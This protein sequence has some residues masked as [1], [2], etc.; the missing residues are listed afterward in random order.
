MMRTFATWED[1]GLFASYMRSEGYF[2]EV[3]DQG[4][5]SLYGPAAI[6][7]IRV[8]L[9]DEPVTAI[10]NPDGG[11][12]DPAEEDG[13]PPM[14]VADEGEAARLFRMLIVGW[15]V[16]SMIVVLRGFL[17]VAQESP[18]GVLPFVW[19]AI[20]SAVL[21]AGSWLALVPAIP[22]ICSS[23]RKSQ[24]SGGYGLLFWWVIL[25]LLPGLSLL[26]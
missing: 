11:A 19:P 23:I 15:V 24:E 21:C 2:A 16:I 8:L 13:I 3:L 17:V 6:G 18:V 9:S 22:H 12:G 14:A 26:Y 20:A 7:G 1:A 25:F 10:E 5:S 4:A